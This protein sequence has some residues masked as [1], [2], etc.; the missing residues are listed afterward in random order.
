MERPWV[1]TGLS[2]ITA[3]LIHYSGVCPG[4]MEKSI[5]TPILFS[6]AEFSKENCFSS[7]PATIRNTNLTRDPSGLYL[8]C[9]VHDYYVEHLSI[10][11]AL[12]PT[13]D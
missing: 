7:E 10:K 2:Q 1:G 5:S 9:P 12:K 6:N 11:S 3:F 13:E 4:R 8:Y